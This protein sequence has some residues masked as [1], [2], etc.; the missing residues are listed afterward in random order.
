MENIKTSKR[1]YTWTVQKRRGDRW[2]MVIDSK[3]PILFPTR[4]IARAV[5]RELQNKASK[6]PRS[7]RVVKLAPNR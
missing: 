3:G 5:S 4:N 7:Y 6:N 2:L 1:T